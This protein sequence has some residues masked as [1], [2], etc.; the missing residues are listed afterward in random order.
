M[1]VKVFNPQGELVGPVESAHVAKTD[2]EW[3]AQLTPEQFKVARGK[4][5]EAPFCGTLLDNKRDGVYACLCC[6]LPLFESTSKFNSG[7]GWPSFFRAIA[8]ENVVNHVDRSYGMV[9]TEI[10]CA[11][12][13]AHLGHVFPDGPAPTRLRYCVNSE[14]LVFVDATEL[15]SLADPAA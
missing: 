14:S 2:A 1:K 15:A 13:D 8:E 3:Q 7:T 5:T 9:R 11:R 12:C 4:G 6:G 10:L